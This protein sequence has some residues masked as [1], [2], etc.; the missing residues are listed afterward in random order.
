ME[1]EQ[2]RCGI[3]QG[4]A[5]KLN[6]LVASELPS[7]VV[8]L[9]RK[10]SL[11]KYVTLELVTLG[12]LTALFLCL[13][14][15]RVLMV[16]VGLALFALVLLTLN[17][18]F[19]K[20][21]IWRQFPAS[22]TQEARLRA[23]LM[24]VGLVTLGF[25]V[26]CGGIGGARG[27]A[28]GGGWAALERLANGHLLV[29]ILGYFPWALLQQTL[30]QFY[31]LGRLRTLLPAG[32]AVLVTGLSTALVH[33]PDVWVTGGIAAAGIFWS[34]FYLRYRFLTPLALSHAVLGSTFYYWVY[35]RDLIEAW[36]HLGSLGS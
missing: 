15:S 24:S 3:D 7:C 16:D 13:F 35:G 17:A 26:V 30:F 29:A 28:A 31:L 4:R 12:T 6:Q 5:V 10:L 25:V 9:M 18:D 11:R 19:T 23:C 2:E 32:L 8:K 33:L 22:G 1:D 21:V 34:F 27:Y 36:R 14:P 20:N